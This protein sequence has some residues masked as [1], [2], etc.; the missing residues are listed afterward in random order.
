[1]NRKLLILFSYLSAALIGFAIFFT[2][3][4]YIVGY[5]YVPIVSDLPHIS[6]VATG[7]WLSSWIIGVGGMT[8]CWIKLHKDKENLRDEHGIC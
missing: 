1:M 7:I 3:G 6:Y 2:I 5:V 4:N 8:V